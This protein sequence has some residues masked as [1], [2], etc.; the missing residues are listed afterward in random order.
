MKKQETDIPDRNQ[1]VGWQ[2]PRPTWAT[3]ITDLITQMQ[4]PVNQSITGLDAKGK[5]VHKQVVVKGNKTT[6]YP[7]KVVWRITDLDATKFNQPQHIFGDVQDFDRSGIVLKPI[8]EVWVLSEVP[9]VFPFPNGEFPVKEQTVKEVSNLININTASIEELQKISGVGA[10][11]AKRI[12]D[13]RPFTDAKDLQRVPGIGKTT[14][15][16]IAAQVSF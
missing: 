14:A 11:L 7:F 10:V 2:V 8:W 3:N 4:H 5:Y 16:K 15:N 1:I 13:A 12:F 6:N 9:T